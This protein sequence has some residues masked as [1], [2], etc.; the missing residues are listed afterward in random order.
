MVTLA[1][2]GCPFIVVDFGTR[3]AGSTPIPEV[4]PAMIL[5]AGTSAVIPTSKNA[6]AF[7]NDFL[8][9]MFSP[10]QDICDADTADYIP[11]KISLNAHQRDCVILVC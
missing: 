4:V 5:N 10:L 2:S 8:I 11:H 9:F 1:D 3:V 6:I 7:W